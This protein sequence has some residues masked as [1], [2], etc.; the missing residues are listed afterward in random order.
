M[1]RGSA[2]PRPGWERHARAGDPQ[3]MIALRRWRILESA[4]AA[5][6]RCEPT[7][8]WISTPEQL[9]DW[10]SLRLKPNEL[11]AY[12]RELEEIARK[13]ADLE[14]LR[15]ARRYLGQASKLRRG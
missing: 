5:F 3:T 1:I 11:R 7:P 8:I 2:D 9:V 4:Q 15:L 14:L 13:I 6:K 12:F 10:L